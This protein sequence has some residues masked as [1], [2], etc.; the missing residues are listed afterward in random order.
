MHKQA[1]CQKLFDN[2]LGTNIHK[3][4]KVFVTIYRLINCRY[5][6]NS[7]FDSNAYKW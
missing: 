5:K 2:A 6:I 3:A 1:F 7:H 4:K